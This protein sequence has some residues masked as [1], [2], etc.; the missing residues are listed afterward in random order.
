MFPACSQKT[1]VGQ[2]SFIFNLFFLFKI[3][4]DSWEYLTHIQME[5]PHPKGVHTYTAVCAQKTPNYPNPSNDAKKHARE[6]SRPRPVSGH[7]V[8]GMGA[9][10]AGRLTRPVRLGHG[11]RPNYYVASCRHRR[12]FPGGSERAGFLVSV[13][14]P[15]GSPI[16]GNQKFVKGGEGIK[17]SPKHLPFGMGSYWRQWQDV[18]VSVR[19]R[20]R[21]S[22]GAFS[23]C[24][25]FLCPKPNYYGGAL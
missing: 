23:Y 7:S 1:P 8:P 24:R 16:F 22:G 15:F 20:P 3:D 17:A 21:S 25:L 14:F 10:Q 9:R 4:W 11:W 5:T 19:P 6:D 13:L 18:R 2:P 12:P